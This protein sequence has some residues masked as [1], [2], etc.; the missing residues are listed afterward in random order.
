MDVT[1][2]WGKFQTPSTA[3]DSFENLNRLYKGGV[4]V[5]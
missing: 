5:R 2:V 1:Q 4:L 3:D